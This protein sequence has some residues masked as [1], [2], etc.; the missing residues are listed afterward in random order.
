MKVY[1][2]TGHRLEVLGGHTEAVHNKA[3]AYARKTLM[4]FRPNRVISGMALGWDQALATAAVELNIPFVA[5]VPFVGQDHVWGAEA[6]SRYRALLDKA[7]HVEIVCE[8]GFA[9]HKYHERDKWMVD[10]SDVVLALW[11]GQKHGGTY[12]TV[13][14]AWKVNREVVNVWD[15]WGTFQIGCPCGCGASC[16]DHCWHTSTWADEG[17]Q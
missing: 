4:Q 10:N 2:G 16:E 8:G 7:E 13:K 14:Y 1:A 17:G 12:S 15:G 5:A 11:N 9:T 3:V 6:Q